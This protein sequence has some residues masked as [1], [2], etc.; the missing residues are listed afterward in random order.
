MQVSGVSLPL[1]LHG[2]ATSFSSMHSSQPPC[3]N[4]HADPPLQVTAG[5]EGP[6]ERLGKGIGCSGL[7]IT[8][9]NFIKNIREH[10]PRRGLLPFKICFQYSQGGL[11]KLSQRGLE[12][13]VLAEQVRCSAF[14]CTLEIICIFINLSIY[15]HIKIKALLSCN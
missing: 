6:L 7:S 4:C 13:L 3:F 9:G 15:F 11:G 2:T 5:F 1:T 10:I 8:K 14:S 12:S